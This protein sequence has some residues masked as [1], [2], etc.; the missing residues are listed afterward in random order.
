MNMDQSPVFLSSQMHQLNLH[1]VRI[2][3]FTKVNV[4]QLFKVSNFKFP[5]PKDFKN[6]LFKLIN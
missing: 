2:V 1:S 3:R 6:L 4:L 5:D